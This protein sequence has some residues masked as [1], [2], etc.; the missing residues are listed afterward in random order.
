[1][2]PTTRNPYA[3]PSAAAENTRP[4]SGRSVAVLVGAAIGNGIAYAVLSISGLVLLW[5]L[6]AQGVPAQELYSR[7]YQSNAYLLFAHFVGLVC[8]LP[9]GYW[10]ARLSREGPVLSAL[11]AGSLVS[12]FTL[13]QNFVPYNFPIPLWSRVASIAI[14]IP[15]F[16]LGALWRH[17][18]RHLPL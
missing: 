14:P 3:P 8:L 17:R 15:A 12:V 7:A 13:A 10:A 6:T 9:G 18:A 16:A 1:M 2:N 11:L 5:V 4:G